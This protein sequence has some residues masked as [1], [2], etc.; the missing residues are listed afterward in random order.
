MHTNFDTIWLPPAERDLVTPCPELPER[1]TVPPVED[2]DDSTPQ[3]LVMAV[4]RAAVEALSGYRPVTQLSRWLTPAAVDGLSMARRHGPWQGASVS[5]V[6]ASQ[7][8]PQIVEGVAQLRLD[9]HRVALPVR[10]ECDG[11]RWACTHLGVLLPGSH[12]RS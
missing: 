7:I 12:I 4:A 1:Q 5:R 2:D 3:A 8:T 9:E 10:L 11:G 6:W